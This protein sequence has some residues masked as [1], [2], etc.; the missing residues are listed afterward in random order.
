MKKSHHK[1]KPDLLVALEWAFK[2]FGNPDAIGSP[3]EEDMRSMYV[4]DRFRFLQMLREERDRW[5]AS[6]PKRN[7]PSQ[8]HDMAKMEERIQR[9]IDEAKSRRVSSERA[10]RRNGQP[11]SPEVL[12]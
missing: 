9:M 6:Q 7:R 8:S 4:N 11:D 3:V 2:N 12:A 1:Q 10:Q 5:E